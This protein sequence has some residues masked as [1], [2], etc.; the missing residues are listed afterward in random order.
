M[1]E[2][3]TPNAT[4]ISGG[5]GGLKI[6]KSVKFSNKQNIDDDGSTW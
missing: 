5:I 4:N 6:K 2:N 1:K 3:N